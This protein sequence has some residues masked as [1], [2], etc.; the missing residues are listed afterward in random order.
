MNLQRHFLEFLLCFI[1]LTLFAQRSISG[2]ITD[3]DDGAPISDIH[4]FIDKTTI[5][6]T[7]NT[8][9]YYQLKIPGEGSYQLVVS[10]VAYQPV[11][12]EIE[13][14][15]AS[16]VIDIELQ[17]REMEDIEIVK[18]V[19]VRNNDV[20]LFWKTLLGEKPSKKTIHATN[21]EDVYFYYNS[22]TQK[23]TVSCRVPI[24]IV[25]YE[26]GYQIQYVLN[27]FTHDYKTKTS[28]WE[29]KFIFYELK[30]KNYR[31]MQLW[32]KNRKNVYRV[33]IANLI[34]SLYQNTMS[35]NGYLFAR[36]VTILDSDPKWFHLISHENFLSV[37]SANNCKTLNMPELWSIMLFCFGNPI[38]EKE[39]QEIDDIVKARKGWSRIGSFRN[40]ISTPQPIQIFPD[41]TYRNSLKLHPKLSSKPLNGLN[42]VLPIDYD[43]DIESYYIPDIIR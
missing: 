34:K 38:T 6:T 43:P 29:G 32:G 37:D 35:E 27:Y 28:S 40:Y 39:L 33:S 18:K 21:P 4:V 10:H 3:A 12:M 26:T 20:D 25:N 1:P 15:K 13:P 31:Q 36:V 30:A 41:G 17:I 22:E 2:R 7:T 9:G 11:F 19:K 23:L 16:K 42:M 5:G 14:G 8:E 24:Q